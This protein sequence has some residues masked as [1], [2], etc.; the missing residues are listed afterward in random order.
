MLT[1]PSVSGIADRER[2]VPWRD[3]QLEERTRVR[4][5]DEMASTNF[6]VREESTSIGKCSCIAQDTQSCTHF[7]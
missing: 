4:H 2:K 5:E 1:L 7:F 3:A 6:I